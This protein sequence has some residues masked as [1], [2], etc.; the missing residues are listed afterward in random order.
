LGHRRLASGAETAMRPEKGP[1][2]R[3][4]QL[5]VRLII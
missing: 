4:D 3:Q 5:N 2:D 1:R